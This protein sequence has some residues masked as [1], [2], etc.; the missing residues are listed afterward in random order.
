MQKEFFYK[1]NMGTDFMGS[2]RATLVLSDKRWLISLSSLLM[3]LTISLAIVMLVAVL[4]AVIILPDIPKEQLSLKLLAKLSTVDWT[5]AF[6]KHFD[7]VAGIGVLIGYIWY[8]NRARK[9]ERL[10]LSPEGIQYTSPLPQSLKRLRPDWSLSWQQV[11]KTELGMN[12]KIQNPE[13]VLLTFM[14]GTK[15][16]RVFP[17]RWV[18]PASYSAPT[19]RFN[20]TF[21]IPARDDILKSALATE[22][23]RY[24][25][26]NVPTITVVANLTQTEAITSLEKNPHGRIAMGIIFLLILY[27]VIDFVI[28]SESY[29]DEP[30]T[31]MHLYIAA[32]IIGTILSAIGLYKSTL[33]AAEKGGL[34]ILI[35]VVVSAA[36]LPGALRINALTDSNG[37]VAYDYYV[38]QDQR[39][40]VLQP[41]V[42]GMPSIDY[43]A[44]NKFWGKFGKDDTYPVQIRKG[45]LGFYQ[46]N[47]S[48]IVDD[49]H[50]YHDA[51]PKK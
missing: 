34:A 21:K 6:F 18:N 13:F 40:V 9:L 41:V 48:I 20:F 12:G 23:V 31:L 2:G 38:K 10:T 19:L 15:K 51:P 50:N 8:L 26:R 11:E 27:A 32:G 30:S 22:I 42:A 47:S 28:G 14:Y 25:S 46:F 5:R 7:L 4:L 39:S 24:I 3:F 36:M 29:I 35:G 43:F 44:A 16:R 37:L 33:A 49:I 45:G 17:T 1:R